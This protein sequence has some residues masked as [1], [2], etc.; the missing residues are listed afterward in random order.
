MAAP[1]FLFLAAVALS[2]PAVDRQE[3]SWGPWQVVGP[4]DHPEGSTDNRP[5]HGPEATLRNMA[6]GA[7]WGGLADTYRGP[8][9]RD[10]RWWPLLAD[11]AEGALAADVGAID[12]LQVFPCPTGLAPAVWSDRAAA[13][14]YRTLEVAARCELDLVFGSDDGLRVWLDGE[15]ALD[16]NLA[17][18][19]GLGDD[20]LRRGLAPGLHHLLVKVNNGGGAWA[21]RMAEYH[22]PAQDAINAA[23]DRGAAYL[24]SS[25]LL[26]GSWG[27]YQ[28]QYRNGET[29]LVAYTLL[30]S[31]VPPRHPALLR[32][33]AYLREEP[34][35]QTYAIA[36]QMMALAAAHDPDYTPWME[37]LLIDLASWQDRMRG[38]WAY[39]EGELDL[40]N[41]QYAALGLRAAEAVGLAVPDKVWQR[42]LEGVF[43]HQE[44]M[45]RVPAVPGALG[46]SGGRMPEAGF[47]YRRLNPK[48][49]TGSMTVAG[50]ATLEICRQ[51]LGGAVGPPQLQQIE[52][53]QRLGLNWLAARFS[54]RGN[55]A[56][57]GFH[58]YYL[59]GLERA[60][61]LLG[62]ELIGEREWYWEGAGVLLA[63][64]RGDGAWVDEWGALPET[65]T[66]YALLFLKRAT[67][68]AT[69]GEGR[70]RSRAVRSREQDGP[71][72]LVVVPGEPC[73][74]YVEDVAEAR[75]VL[76][77]AEIA[78]VIYRVRRPGG[79]WEEVGRGLA[80]G[81]GSLAPARY[82][83]RHSFAQPGAWE[84]Q[85][86]A[87]TAEG[88]E[89]ASGVV[90]FELEQG[91][92]QAKLRYAGDAARN[93]L[94]R[95]R[96]EAVASSGNAGAAVD[97]L[98]GTAWLCDAQDAAPEFEIRLKRGV[99]A[100]HLLLG[101]AR[102]R[103][104]ER[105]NNPRPTR[106]EILLNRDTEPL[107]V[108]VDPDPQA[109][110]VID[111]GKARSVARVR[112]RIVEVAD[113]TLGAAAVGFGEVELQD[114][115]R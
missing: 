112:L 105:A 39:P 57:G 83:V 35:A 37:E 5:A 22:R 113:G 115:G 28:P 11:E 23:I 30:K 26:D 18:A 109:K 85:A 106:V 20:R 58:H 73:A 107:V 25:Q 82:P 114:A 16:R 68:A 72:R 8:D 1:A 91:V 102:T 65:T 56:G 34:P 77:E 29:A 17:R 95:V 81:D 52:Q 87:R 24:L 54:V 104:R 76:A 48:Q 9:R 27:E 12:F 74:F 93:L 31:G 33:F 55:P 15:L 100:S 108:E 61:S 88:A 71:P 75:A 21:F 40:S 99:R 41:T 4:F 70:S 2:P 36:C 89:L 110:T 47:A 45:E 62:T 42:L 43:D 98:W 51:G 46:E 7:P 103:P 96:P 92:E 78:E 50:V 59:Y 90:A 80:R 10:L 101:H 64:Q 67:A 14:L 94:L 66:C 32:A 44:R 3:P 63:G 49:P 60:G 69:T 19:V 6:H 111:L 38:A 97:G 79:E 13:Y 53:A 84:V 86:V